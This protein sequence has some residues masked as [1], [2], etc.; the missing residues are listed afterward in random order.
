MVYDFA[1]RELQDL[2]AMGPT[3]ENR[4]MIYLECVQDIAEMTPSATGSICAIN[5]FLRRKTTAS[6]LADIR[7]LTE[8]LDLTTLL[9]KEFAHGIDIERA[10]PSHG[11][12][13]GAVI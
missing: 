6:G 4:K 3:N 5:A 13:N 10:K 12:V 8:E 1:A 2:V 7:M 9:V 11:R